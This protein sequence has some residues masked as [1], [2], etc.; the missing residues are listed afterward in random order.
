MADIFISYAREDIETAH[1]LA[2]ALEAQAWSVFWDR[3]IP[4]GQSW[5]SYIG[6]ALND[7]RC[8]IVLWSESSL[9]SEFVHEEADAAKRRDVLL[10]VL[11][12]SVVPPLGFGQIQA[13]DLIG[14]DGDANANELLQFLNAVTT[15]LGPS[16]A[17]VA[18]EKQ[19]QADAKRREVEER[20]GEEEARERQT[21]ERE[22]AERRQEQEAK[23]KRLKEEERKREEEAHEQQRKEREDAERRR[24]QEA[25]A[26][27]L[28][29]EERK[30]EEKQKEKIKTEKR[31]SRGE[32]AGEK[33]DTSVE[34][35]ATE[36]GKGKT[37]NWKPILI[38]AAA[39]VLLSIV[40]GIINY[41][42]QK[43]LAT[44]PALT[45]MSEE[46]ATQQL[47]DRRYRFS[48]EKE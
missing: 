9:G 15:Y 11:I 44:M 40:I 27:R 21:R 10:P 7:A 4:P 37:R 6:K 17:V 32:L 35:G 25:E 23:A 2:D 30:K 3:T 14:W 41:V 39:L 5:R 34:T 12:E 20:K 48:V 46:A 43:D 24:E 42:A 16:P 13:A 38:S 18:E 31:P 26:K 1:R 22:E 33:A 29:E 19:K 36:R 47:V 28:K 8:V 45:R